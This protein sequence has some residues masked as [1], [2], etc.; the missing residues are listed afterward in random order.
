MSEC[1]RCKKPGY[2]IE[3]PRGGDYTTCPLCNCYV[4]EDGDS[5]DGDSGGDENNIYYSEKY[6]YLLFCEKC[7]I[8]F[9]TGCKHA[10]NGCTDDIHNAHF[11]DLWKYKNQLEHGM[12]KFENRKDMLERLKDIEILKFSCPNKGL[13]C[14]KASYPTKNDCDIKNPG[15]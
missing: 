15:L 7:K 2:Y 11:I 1:W 13:I 5:E 3:F 10:I 6:E 14:E 9:E 12:P 4:E 8:L